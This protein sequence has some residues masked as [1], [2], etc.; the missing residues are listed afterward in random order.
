MLW[1]LR[2]GMLRRFTMVYC[3]KTPDQELKAWD[4]TVW[5]IMFKGYQNFALV[6]TCSSKFVFIDRRSP[7]TESDNGQVG[8]WLVRLN[9]LQWHRVMSPLIVMNVYRNSK[10]G[11][12][13]IVKNQI[14][15]RN[16]LFSNTDL[17]IGFFI[18]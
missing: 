18:D 5:G 7:N 14:F 9:T 2:T 12:Y 11:L 16:S 15:L 4:V 17:V 13:F 8:I 6:W 10:Q 1:V 3:W